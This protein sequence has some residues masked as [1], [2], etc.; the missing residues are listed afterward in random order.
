MSLHLLMVDIQLQIVRTQY[1]DNIHTSRL[2]LMKLVRKLFALILLLLVLC[3]LDLRSV[4]ESVGR[5]MSRLGGDHPE[6]STKI[7]PK[8]KPHILMWAKVHNENKWTIEPSCPL[9]DRCTITYNK[10]TLADADA[11]FFAVRYIDPDNMPSSDLRR[12]K[13]LN[14]LFVG[15]AYENALRIHRL[16]ETPSRNF[17]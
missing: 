8:R 17:L 7:P 12:P 6:L 5:F 13:A 3:T 4:R 9:V 2:Y 10:S 15:E 11:L 14:V 1:T 16:R